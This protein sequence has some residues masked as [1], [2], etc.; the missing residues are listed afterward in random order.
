M[1]VIEACGLLAFFGVLGLIA[2]RDV[3]KRYG[4]G[5]ASLLFGI[6]LACFWIAIKP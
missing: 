2:Q 6:Y 5:T 4:W 3:S 1:T